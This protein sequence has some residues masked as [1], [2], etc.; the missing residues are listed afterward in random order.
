MKIR[1]KGN[2][3]RY[4]LSKTEVTMLAENGLLKEKTEFVSGILSYA[5]QQTAEDNLSAD[6]TQNIITL[7]VPQTALQQWASSSQVGMESSMPL[8]NGGTLY[9]LLEKDFKCIDADVSEDQSDYYENP[10]LTC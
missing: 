2:T 7:Y 10:L 4:R 8:P 1:I 6:F 5:I 3:V 9:L